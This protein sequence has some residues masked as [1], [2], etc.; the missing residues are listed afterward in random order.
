MI[1]IKITDEMKNHAII[2]SKKRDAFIKHHFEVGHLTYE[3]RDQLGFLGEFACCELLGIDWKKNI[4]ENYLTIDDYD[5][6]INAKRIDIKT[7]TV[8]NNYATKIIN[9]TIKDD[10]LYGRRLINKG[11]FGLLSKYDY[12]FFSL[13]IRENMDYWYPIG[14]IE[15]QTIR[16]N[17]PVTYNRPDGGTYPFPAS[18]VPTSLLKSY[19]KLKNI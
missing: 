16:N 8:P 15:S 6:I 11:Q 18:P 1:K 17:F 14:F 4:R 19:E 2:E 13:F 9:N 10:E 12:V 5:L 7:E 3:Q